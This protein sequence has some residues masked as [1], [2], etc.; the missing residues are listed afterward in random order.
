M[1]YL[2]YVLNFSIMIFAPFLL[3][4]FINNRRKTGWG[5]FGV[6][7]V[8][9][10]LS[11]VGH[12]PFNWLILRKLAWVPTDTA[13]P[14]NLLALAIFAGLSAGIF[15]ESARYLTYRFWAKDARSWGKG[16][17]LGIGHGGIEAIL[18][19]ILGAWG[20]FQLTAF[21]QG[22]L[23][24]LIPAEQMAMVEEQITAVFSVPWYRALLGALERLLALAIHLSLS[25]LVMQGFVSKQ[26]RWLI[27]AILW[28][29]VIDALAVFSLATWNVYITEAI[30]GGTAVLSLIVIF[31]LRSAEP[32][33]PILE[34]LPELQPTP[35]ILPSLS[36]E[37]L[38]RSRFAN[39]N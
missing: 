27:L 37:S 18:L 38:D 17:M 7:A 16:L 3:A 19:G 20:V 22:Y 12:I 25:L 6:G 35:P 1:I 15:E 9:F 30:V 8:T 29:A 31:W 4:R 39:N 10:V 34:P 26:R 11:Q 14:N 13:V 5:L 2:I 36:A 21:S 33:E 32:M 24:N 23:L 28:H